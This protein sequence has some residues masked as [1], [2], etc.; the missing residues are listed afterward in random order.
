MGST[1][2]GVLVEGA[3]VFDGHRVLPPTT[4]LVLEGRVA[5]LGDRLGAPAGLPGVRADGATL[6]PGLVDAH[7]HLAPG[8]LRAAVR[9][10]V[11]TVVDMFAD[12]AAA[13]SA[14]EE[15]AADPSAADLRSAGFGATTPGGHPTRLVGQGLLP[16]FP[17]VG[18]PDEAAA[19]VAAR[20]AEGSDHLK[21]VLEDGTTTGRPVPCLDAGTVRALVRA[22]H[23][24][25]LRVVAH[26][27][28][29][30]HALLAL[31][32]GVDGLAHLFLDQPPSP[33]FVEAAVRSGAFVVPTLTSLAAR[34]GHARGRDLA[35]DPRIG[36]LLDPHARDLLGTA[37]PAAPGA[38]ADL[39]H[40]TATA[41]RLHEAGVP[42]LAGTDAAS[43]GTAHGASLHDEL[44][45]L[46]AAGLSPVAAL[47]AATS[48]PAAAF[49]LPDRGRIAPGLRADLLLVRGE[50]GREVTGTR[51]VERVWRA[52]REA[53]AA[54]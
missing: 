8:A 4:V 39:S 28:T 49:G 40:A 36:H 9:F 2:A 44:A 16:P 53:F 46:V 52:G 37:F 33:G 21:V 34:A 51:A 13:R 23:D 50:P 27:L 48:A 47:A 38:R 43:P 5:A 7:V 6:L 17:T 12:P 32:A 19:F 31:D 3:R 11:T 18:G 35:A 26:T 25:G 10:G 14:K 15:A 30:A 41:A 22:A 20:V 24:R 42:L 54:G 29:R 45:L 1:P